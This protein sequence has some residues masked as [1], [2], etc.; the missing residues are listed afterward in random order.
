MNI[1]ISGSDSRTN[2][3]Y[4]KSRSDFNL[5]LTIN[6]KTKDI[7]MTSIPRDYYVPLAN[8][9]GLSDKLTHSGIYGL[10][11]SVKTIE[12]LLDIKIDYSIKINFESVITLVDL[13]GG[14]DI[15][16]DKAFRTN[17][18]DG[19]AKVTN[20]VLGLNHFNGAEALSYAR[21]RYAYNEGDRHRI[22]NGQQVLK[23]VMEKIMNDK[24]L[25][26]KYNDILKSISKL[27]VTDMESELIKK[28]I[29]NQ[30]SDMSPYHF[31]SNW[32]SGSDA[33]KVT[34]TTPNSNTYVMIPYEDDVNNATIKINNILN[35]QKRSN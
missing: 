33:R 10:D 4:N 7:L 19:G 26:L 35:K 31:Q 24:T 23:S 30:I 5:I 8:K 2:Q 6:P 14:V 28:I 15:Y 13:V 34:Y 25:L 16:S 27:Y 1:Y 9:D 20:V 21:E 11:T 12:N 29:K 3:I 17:C 22:Q 18:G 32:I